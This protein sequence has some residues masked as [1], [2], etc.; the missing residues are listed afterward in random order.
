MIA[1]VTG[2]SGFIGRNLVGRLLSD[3]HDVR[4][5]TRHGGGVA[6]AGASQAQVD[7]RDA[8]SLRT[9]HVLDGADVVFHLAAA[10]R[11]RTEADFEAAN[12]TP[13]R[14]LLDALVAQ[15]SP[16][17]FV[18][19]SSQA[20]AGP[21]SSAEKAVIEADEPR[22]VEAYGRSKL[23]AERL[24][25]SFADRVPVTIARPSSVFGRYD[26]D[27]LRL[28]QM[29]RR[30]FIVYPGT[31]RHWL[32]LAHVDDVVAGLLAVAL[33]P[34]AMGRTYFLANEAPLQWRSLGERVAT[35]VGHSV[36]HLNVPGSLVQ[37]ASHLGDLAA[38]VMR[39]TPLLNSNKAALARHP[40]WLCSAERARN[41]L[42]WQASGSLPDA[43]RD[44]YL[45]YEQ[46]GWLSGSPR[47]AFAVA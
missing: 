1:V 24:T 14:T 13:T 12:V 30:G 5:L 22:P 28:F 15:E 46:S 36:S 40:F 37:A 27:F 10:T 4:C 7:F 17:R 44:T 33:A 2:A 25:L 29:A 47:S 21:A 19:V 35:A 38:L 41:D 42:G 32:S 18:L 11:A 8:A 3:G 26:R 31:E 39:D 23:A 16:G 34:Q 20:A 43:L 6:P 9:S 45:W